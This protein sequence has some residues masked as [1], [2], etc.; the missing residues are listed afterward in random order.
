M[1][2]LLLKY[3]FALGLSIFFHEFGHWIVLRLKGYKPVVKFFFKSWNKFGFS[4]LIPDSM[5]SEEKLAVLYFGI[6]FGF[7][8]LVSLN[9]PVQVLLLYLIGCSHDIKM[10]IGLY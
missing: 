7:G 3:F 6:V 8:F 1:I 4:M 5:S 2:V 9:M 10:I